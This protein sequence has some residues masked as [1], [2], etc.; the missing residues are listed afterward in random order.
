MQLQ[1][2]LELVS[3]SYQE[4]DKDRY[5]IE[6]SLTISTQEMQDLYGKLKARSE[7]ELAR[8]RAMLRSLVDSIPDLIFFKDRDSRYLGCNLAFCEYVGCSEDELIGKTDFD[9]FE[10]ERAEIIRSEDHAIMHQG[11]SCRSEE[12]ITYP[13]NRMHL[14]DSIKSPFHGA[15][16]ELLGLI[17]IGRDITYRKQAEEQLH[18][19]THTVEQ[20]ASVVLIVDARNIIKYVNSK[21]TEVTGYLPDEVI[22]RDSQCLQSRE[23]LVEH[24]KEMQ[25]AL[26]NGRE[27]RGEVCNRKK[28][29]DRYWAH[30]VISPIKDDQGEIT[31]YLCTVEDITEA[32]QLNEQLSYEAS[33]DSLTGLVNRREFEARVQSLLD[34]NSSR[35][36]QHAICFMDLDQFK[37]VNDTC[38]HSAGDEL[39][40]QVSQHLSR[41]V[42][43]NDTLARLGGDEFGM[44]MEYCSL[45]NARKVAENLQQ[46]VKDFQFHWEDRMFKIGVSIGLVAITYEDHNLT[47]LFRNADAACYMAKDLGRNRIHVYT[48]EDLDLAQR[49][50]EMEW[51]TRIYRALEENQLQLYAQTI[52]PVSNTDGKQLHYE[53]LLRMQ[54]DDGSIIPPGS[55]LPAAE[56]YNLIAMLD[57]WV[58][59]YSFTKLMEYPQF[60]SNIGL[61][62]IN[63][64]GQS[65]TEYGFLDF[66]IDKLDETGMQPEKI[67]FEITETAAIANLSMASNFIASLRNIGCS[68]ALDD[69]GS[70]LSS[71]GYLKNLP[72][73]YLKIDGMFVRDIL[74]D[75]IDRAMVKSINEIGQVMGME[76]IA[77]FVE[78]DETI[79]MLKEIGVDYVQGY[80]FGRPIP[81]MDILT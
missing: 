59:N 58:I 47:E 1:Q 54:D 41:H 68:F 69:F 2:L 28:S 53:F 29:G 49:H 13:D 35:Q 73:D 76:T 63:L 9:L 52:N 36:H 43:S 42:R 11:E 37:V 16:G 44:L 70:G 22:G 7:S 5:T 10:E 40:R 57:R 45:E 48:R 19:L 56:R 20:S 79:G 6:R 8:D 55:F 3:R 75:P 33:H 72:V 78:N 74:S 38:G 39:L 32:H 15:D 51:V 25:N 62:S 30:I 27:W 80:A 46:L 21:F 4:S 60:L 67:C 61:C 14:I 34:R 31:Y 26:E 65:L 24:G 81:L 50:G 12:W 66:I 17:G 23:T 71:F 18:V 77:E 64:S